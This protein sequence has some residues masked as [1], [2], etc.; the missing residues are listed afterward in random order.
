MESHLQH[1]QD[2]RDNDHPPPRG[3][4]ST[5]NDVK[6]VWKGGE[7]DNQPVRKKFHWDSSV[8]QDYL[9]QNRRN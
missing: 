4:N 8:K 7:H 3:A 5:H 2:H 6:W 1:G 9:G